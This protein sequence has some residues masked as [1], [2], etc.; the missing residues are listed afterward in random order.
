MWTLNV[1]L[2]GS[3]KTEFTYTSPTGA[4]VHTDNTEILRRS[5][6][7]TLQEY[8]VIIDHLPFL[9]RAVYQSRLARA[10]KSIGTMIYSVLMDYAQGLYRLRGSE[11]VVPYEQF[12]ID[13]TEPAKWPHLEERWG[14]VGI[15]RQFLEWFAERFEFCGAQ[16]EERFKDNIR[17]MAERLSAF[18]SRLI[19]L[20][21]AEVPLQHRLGWEVDRHLHHRRMNQALEEIVAELPNAVICDVRPFVTSHQD[22]MDNL[23]HYK[24]EPYVRIAEHLTQLVG[25][26]VAFERRPFFSRLHRARRRIARKLD[27]AALS[28]RLR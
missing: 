12:D 16:S 10:P 7:E 5:S 24:R 27:H 6:R 19:L 14:D 28:L 26:D 8:G 13:V 2:G 3:I 20:N 15:N 22:L 9:D 21:G 17:W 25:S 18:G 1:F 23:R 4:E 11:F